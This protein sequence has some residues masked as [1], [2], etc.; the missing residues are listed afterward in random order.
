MTDHGSPTELLWFRQDLR[1]AGNPALAA[2][3]ARGG[4]LIPVYIHAPEEEGDWP[5]GAAS[6]WWLAGSLAALDAD[7]RARG[8]RL[9]VLRGPTADALRR[10]AAMTGATA[11]SWNRRY[12]PAAA[13]RDAALATSLPADGLHVRIH[14]AALLAEPWTVAT[15]AGRPF[16][17]FTPFWRAQLRQLDPPLP[18]PAPEWIPGPEDWPATLPLDSLGLLPVVP[19]DR[20]MR[21]CWQPGESGAHAALERFLATAFADPK[22]GLQA[23]FQER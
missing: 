8:S 19:W 1:L 13:A 16:Q 15:Q 11:V 23:N 7:L 20:A 6:C 21:A 3:L 4:P 17:V 14:A 10:L 2:A 18:D 22:D 5:P 12:E 9:T